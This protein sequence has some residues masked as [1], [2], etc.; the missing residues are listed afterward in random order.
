MLAYGKLSRDLMAGGYS[1]GRLGFEFAGLLP[2]GGAAEAP[3]RVM[4]VARQAIATR[5]GAPKYLVRRPAP[6]AP[7]R[8]SGQPPACSPRRQSR[9]TQRQHRSRPP[10]RDSAARQDRRNLPLHNPM[11]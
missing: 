9:N 2:G 5:V 6:P 11:A 4:G 3:R 10:R 8:P 7:A 1:Q